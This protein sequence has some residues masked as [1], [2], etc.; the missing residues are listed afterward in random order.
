MGRFL[1]RAFGFSLVFSNTDKRNAHLFYGSRSLSASV[2]DTE[3]SVISHA[4]ARSVTA[5]HQ[6]S[7]NT[8]LFIRRDTYLWRVRCATK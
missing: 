1:F 5:V 2:S 7:S 4:V 8:P 6:L 3:T